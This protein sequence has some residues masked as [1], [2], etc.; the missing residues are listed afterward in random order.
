MSTATT[1][2]TVLI[3]G[4]TSAI[5]TATARCYAADRARFFLVARSPERL[6]AIRDDLL[7]RGATQV[8]TYALD[9]TDLDGHAAMLAAAK[10]ALGRIDATLVA[11]GTLGNQQQSEASV[12][13]TL[14]EWHTNATSTIALLTLLA[15]EL[16]RQRGGTLAVISSVAGDRGRRSNYVYGAAKGALSIFLQGLRARLRKAGV[17]VVTIKP[18][19]VDTP[20]TAHLRKGPLFASPERVGRDIYAAM[21][22]GRAVVYT[23]GY[24]RLVMFVLR[25]IPEP[26]FIR[27]PL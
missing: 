18:G 21:R 15:N 4:A 17:R 11:Y 9:L 13:A 3:I 7:V 24:W 16:E 10:A 5:A 6:A 25:A 1:T 26:I 22:R 14:R 23:P 8:D 2:P 19:M 27:L 12:E 20:M